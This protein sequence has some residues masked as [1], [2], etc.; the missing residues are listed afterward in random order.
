MSLRPSKSKAPKAS[1]KTKQGA[2]EAARKAHGAMSV[3]GMDFV[4][5]N[6]GAGWVHE[7]VPPG[8]K[9]AAKAQAKRRAT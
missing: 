1:H 7:P 2:L 6:T 4:L 3:E 8:N 5:R 9:A